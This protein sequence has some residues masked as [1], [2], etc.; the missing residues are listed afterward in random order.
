MNILAVES[1][2]WDRKQLERLVRK[3]MPKGATLHVFEKTDEAFAFA[4]EHPIDVA[5]IDLAG[6]HV[7]GYFLAK[8]LLAE[9]RL[10]IIFTNYEW[11]HLQEAMTLR[12]SG[13]IRKPLRFEDVAAEFQ[14]LRYPVAGGFSST[15]ADPPVR[16]KPRKGLLGKLARHY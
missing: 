15:G 12:V 7:P 6:M 16:T 13:Y 3:A 14:N 5:F 10:N 1:L 2:W 8:K 9:R 4:Q 11:E